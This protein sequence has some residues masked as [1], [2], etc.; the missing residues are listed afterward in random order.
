MR[1][2]SILFL[3]T[4]VVCCT[5]HQFPNQDPGTVIVVACAKCHVPS[6]QMQWL[7]TLI[8]DMKTDVSSRGDIYAISLDN[9]TLFVHQP[10]I[11]SCL[12]CALYECDGT[13]PDR[14]TINL[15]ALHA[16]MSQ[17]NIIYSYPY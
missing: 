11:M 16:Q 4:L 7:Q 15:E 3:V 13:R 14:A 10:L 5:D 8:A 2:T 17:S 12:G 1:K 9:K 6:E